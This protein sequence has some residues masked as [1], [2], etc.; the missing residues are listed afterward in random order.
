MFILHPAAAISLAISAHDERMAAARRQHAHAA[1]HA[2]QMSAH[3]GRALVRVGEWLLDLNAQ[4]SR[5]GAQVH[6]PS[7]VTCFLSNTEVLMI[8]HVDAIWRY[9]DAR[10]DQRRRSG[11][12][13]CAYTLLSVFSSRS[14]R[15]I[16]R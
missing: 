14:P 6:Y 12:K 5:S 4:P 8:D 3:A 9:A 13:P 2:P 11:H 15:S 7:P 1:Q 10:A 16:E